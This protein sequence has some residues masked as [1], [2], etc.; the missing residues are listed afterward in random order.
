MKLELALVEEFGP[1]FADG[2]GAA[3]FRL[4]RIE[5]YIDLCAEIVVDLSGV[6]NANSSLVNALVAGVLQKR[7]EG[8]ASPCC[9]QAARRSDQG[10]WYSGLIVN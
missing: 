5:P 4:R 9:I 3:C 8:A 10:R 7:D 6:R 2:E 1:H